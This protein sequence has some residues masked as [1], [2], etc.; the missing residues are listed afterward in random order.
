MLSFFLHGPQRSEH[1]LCL[2]LH[3]DHDTKEH[4]MSKLCPRKVCIKYIF[5]LEKYYFSHKLEVVNVRKE[6]KMK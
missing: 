2:V 3:R 5:L 1:Q 4:W 6:I